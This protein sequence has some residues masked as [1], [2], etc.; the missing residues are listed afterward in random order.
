ARGG[1]GAQSGAE[2][3]ATPSRQS[4]LVVAP[5]DG[6]IPPMTPAG[7]TRVAT[8]RSTYFLDFPNDVVAHPFDN[9]EDLGPYD[10]CITRGVTAGMLPTLYSMGTEILQAP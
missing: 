2:R 9:F 6:K 1:M 7:L 10:R 8:S 5:P 4:S 3:Q